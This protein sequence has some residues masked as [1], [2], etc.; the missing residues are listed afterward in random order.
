MA[1]DSPRAQ[2]IAKKVEFIKSRLG[3]PKEMF[4]TPSEVLHPILCS[5][6]SSA[7]M[8]LSAARSSA[9][10]ASASVSNIKSHLPMPYFAASFIIF[11][12]ISTLPPAVCGMPLSSKVKAITAPPYFLTR[13][14]TASM[15]SCLPLTEFTSGLPL[16]RRMAFSIAAGEEVSICRGRSVTA[17]ISQIHFARTSVSSISG[18]PTLTSRICTP[19]SSWETASFKI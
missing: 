15:T 7:S 5:M 12:A 6:T 13:G 17:W 3:R 14:K 9:D 16:Y 10:A 11:F 8:A 1:A 19:F 18:R 4:E 2:A